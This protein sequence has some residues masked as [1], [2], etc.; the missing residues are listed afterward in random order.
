VFT[1]VDAGTSLA[2]FV[3]ATVIFSLGLSPVFTLT[4][5][6]IVG[7]APPERAGAAAAIS[8]TSA[9]FG[10]ALG[11]AV[12][13]TIGVAVYRSVMA[14]A[15]PAGVPPDAVEA[16]LATLGGAVATAAQLPGQLGSALAEAAREAFMQ[17]LRVSAAISVLGTLALAVFT[18]A[19]LRNARPGG[20]A[21]PQA[22][23]EESR[24]GPAVGSTEVA[25]GVQM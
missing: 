15:L 4:T 22:E 14:G 12:Y 10:G 18:V 3:A 8:E 21:Q 7:S 2:V 11:I 20:G 13:G 16:A 19:T 25:P 24:P 5:D 9:E 6:L 1:Q 23:R 17:G